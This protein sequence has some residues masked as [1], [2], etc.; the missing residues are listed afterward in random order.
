[1]WV[2]SAVMETK[3]ELNGIIRNVKET[4]RNNECL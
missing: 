3:T 1:M 4:D 2:I